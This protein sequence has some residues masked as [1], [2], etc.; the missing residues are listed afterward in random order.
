[1]LDYLDGRLTAG[2]R[3]GYDFVDVRDVANGIISALDSE[4]CGGCYIL[5][6]G[7]HSVREL[8]DGLHRASG[9]KPIRTYLPIWFATMTA[10][11]AEAWYKMLRQPPLYTRYSLYTLQSNGIFSNEKSQRELGFTARPLME[12]LQDTVEWLTRKGRT[13]PLHRRRQMPCV[14]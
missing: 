3:G 1:M 12:T 9:R 7:Y 11:L 6:G 4:K 8:L 2:V 13:K 5:S 10:P 14:Q